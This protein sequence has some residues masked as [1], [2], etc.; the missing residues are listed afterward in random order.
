MPLVVAIEWLFKPATESTF[1]ACG[2]E[3][4]GANAAALLRKWLEDGSAVCDC[5][6]SGSVP[7]LTQQRGSSEIAR[8]ASKDATSFASC[9]RTAICSSKAFWASAVPAT[10]PLPSERGQA[11][12]SCPCS[13]A[14]NCCSSHNL[15]VCTT[16]MSRRVRVVGAVSLMAGLAGIATSPSCGPPRR[17]ESVAGP[18]KS[19]H[20][21]VR[22]VSW[23]E[24][25]TVPKR[26]S[27]RGLDLDL[28]LNSEV[29]IWKGWKENSG[30]K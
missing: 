19:Q 11:S 20:P 29:D 17:L 14:P 27:H 4:P 16:T 9:S 2:V 18:R 6:T 24:V 26:K 3:L 5:V 10:G 30:T 13:H 12:P 22:G 21:N 25:A 28:S 8:A 1:P 7:G 23:S 15:M